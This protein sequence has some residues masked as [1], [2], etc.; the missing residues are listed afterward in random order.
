[1]AALRLR[2]AEGVH[3]LGEA[4][5]DHNAA[6][7]DVVLQVEEATHQYLYAKALEESEQAA[8]REAQTGLDAAETR[9]AAGLATVADV[10]QAK[11]RLSQARLALDTV[12]GQIQT[13]RGALATA[14]GLP[15]NTAFDVPTPSADLPL[16]QGKVEVER[17]I[18]EALAQRPDLAAARAEVEKARA[19]VRDKQ[20][21]FRPSITASTNAGRIYYGAFA[22]GQDTYT[23]S[24]LLTIPVFDGGIRRYD[25][26]KAEADRDAAQARLDSL[27]QQVTL[28]VWSTYYDHQT[29]DQRVRA[30]AD[31]LESAR[32]S[33]EVAEARYKAGVGSILDLLTAQQ[34]LESARAQDASARA[35]WAITLARFAHATGSLWRPAPAGTP[36]TEGG[37]P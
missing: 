23:A 2:R 32:Q 34:A 18:Q 33:H 6:I 30:A 29:A 7:Q 8:V 28:E 36:G 4:G 14:V 19:D 20:A 15:A 25:L 31:L 21:A 11:T 5:V 22:T 10:L 1:M 12:Q 3:R 13:V 26:F 9:R 37:T 35:D 24:L 17:A 16:E 27:A